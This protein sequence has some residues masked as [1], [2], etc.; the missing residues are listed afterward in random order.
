MDELVLILVETSMLQH[1]LAQE[2]AY[3]SHFVLLQ[4]AYFCSK[5]GKIRVVGELRV[6]VSA[7]V[8]I[9]ASSAVPALSRMEEAAADDQTKWLSTK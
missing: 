3:C 5:L 8:I 7:A 1:T 4:T 6:I 9:R 2:Y